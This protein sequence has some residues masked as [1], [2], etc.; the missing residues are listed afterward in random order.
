MHFDQNLGHNSAII[1]RIKRNF[2]R[3][4]L[5]P[6]SLCLILAGYIVVPLVLFAK[7]SVLFATVN[8]DLRMIRFDAG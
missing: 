5:K 6:D 4:I 7:L 8:I 3:K 1:F 2:W